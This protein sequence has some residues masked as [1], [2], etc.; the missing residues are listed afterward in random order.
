MHYVVSTDTGGTFTDAV[1]VDEEGQIVIGKA[2]SSP[3]NLAIGI[4]GAVEAAAEQLGMDGETVLSNCAAFLNGTTVGTNAL[5]ERKGAKTG[6]LITKGFEDT[7]AIGRVKGRWVGRSE[8]ELT[9]LQQADWPPPIVPRHLVRGLTER[10]DYQGR[11][12]CPLALPDVRERIEELLGEGMEALAVSLLWSFKNPV[13]EQQV[14]ELVHKE[15]PHLYLTLSSEIAPVIMEY[16]RTSTT[17]VNS[18]LGIALSR[19]IKKLQEAVA[20]KSY[21]NEIL[22]MQSIGGLAPASQIEG[23]SV[24]TLYSGPAGGVIGAL[25]QGLAIGEKNIVTTDMG[26]TSFD[27]GLIVDGATQHDTSSVVERAMLMVPAVA[28]KTV[29]AGGGSVAWLDEAGSLRVGPASQGALPGP[30]C[31]GRGGELPT[32][33]DADVVLGYINPDYFLGGA[34]QISRARAEAAIKTIAAPLGLSVVEA[35]KGIYR[36][37]NSHMADLIRKVTI[38]RGYDPRNFALFAFGGCGPVH[39]SAY[40]AEVGARKIIVPRHAATFSALGIAMSDFRHFYEKSCI[41]SFPIATLQATAEQVRI[42]NETF[43]ELTAQA[44]TQLTKDRVP[45]SQWILARKA[46]MRYQDQIHELTVP[47]SA[48]GELDAAGLKTLCEDFR[49]QYEL[50]YGAGSS[51]QRADISLI[52]LRVDALGPIPVKYNLARHVSAGRDAQP[53]YV[54]LRPV[55]W[56]KEKSPVDTPIYRGEKLAPGNVIPGP[57]V[58]ESYGTTVPVDRGQELVVDE[59]LNLVISPRS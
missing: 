43:R 45:R 53:A 17:V 28:V 35:A 24:T 22:V 56:V 42:V 54:G 26:G 46:D 10:I 33:T 41:L 29:G 2:P 48:A 38:E 13:H 39:C 21:K 50:V 3:Q 7:L 37:V 5:I 12:L 9:N 58:I 59:C 47:L 51:S 30:A 31:Y 36:I 49:H 16:E 27:V 6:L 32:V 57:A 1:I 40:G 4:I 44:E 23:L 34:M 15:Y 52:N 11:V 8:A 25:K 19:Y 20:A 55:W 18:Y 14:R